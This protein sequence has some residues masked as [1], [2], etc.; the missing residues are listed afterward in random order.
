MALV[1]YCRVRLARGEACCWRESAINDVAAAY[2]LKTNW[3]VGR[4]L[5]K[6]H[7]RTFG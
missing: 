1:V 4:M 2:D 3:S 5:H 7:R 6:D